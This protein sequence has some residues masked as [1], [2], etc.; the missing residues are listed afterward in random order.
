MCSLS[1]EGSPGP[2]VVKEASSAL[3][4]QQCQAS[5]PGSVCPWNYAYPLHSATASCTHSDDWRISGVDS[6]DY[7]D[8]GYGHGQV[9]YHPAMEA[10]D[11]E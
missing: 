2:V 6:Q 9:S 5:S 7:V 11:R 10:L 4:Q 1:P 8:S 3:Q